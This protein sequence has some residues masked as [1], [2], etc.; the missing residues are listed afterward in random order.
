MAPQGRYTARLTVTSPL[1][2]QTLTRT[3][4]ATGFVVTPSASSVTSGQ[5]LTVRVE[6]VEPLGTKPIVTFTQPGRAGVSMTATKLAD[7]SYRAVFKVAAGTAGAGSIKV[8]AKDTGGHWNT[9]IVA[10]AV[11]AS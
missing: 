4:W 8:T 7:G 5:T 1:G 2:T 11:R 10:I 3:V 6:T 9:T